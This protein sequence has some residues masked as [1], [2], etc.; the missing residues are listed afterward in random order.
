MSS[1]LMTSTM[2]SDPSGRLVRASSF[3]V[4]VSA[5]ARRAVGGSADGR[6]GAAGG[7]CAGV[8]AAA[9]V[10]GAALAAPATATPARNL[11]RSNFASLSLRDIV[12]PFR[13]DPAPFFRLTPLRECRT[14]G[15]TYS[16]NC[17]AAI[18][19]FV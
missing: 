14:R 13:F 11:R 10:G 4:P 2:K 3:G 12:A 7:V 9:P 19:Q 5:A 17:A 1:D 18:A 8:A 16:T 6:G 15:G